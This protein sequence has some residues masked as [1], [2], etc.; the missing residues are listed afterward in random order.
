MSK[1]ILSY[2]VEFLG[3]FIFL[4]VIAAIGEPI[5]IA[6]A[7]LAMIYF[8]GKISGGSFNPAVSFL[9]FM[10]NKLSSTKFI[11]YVIMELLG[12][13]AAYHLYIYTQGGVSLSRAAA[14]SLVKLRS[15]NGN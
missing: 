4:Y 5:A 15:S 12:A 11:G 10:K 1:E 6:V 3:T 8:G 14:H 2:F 13:Y 9:L 7:L